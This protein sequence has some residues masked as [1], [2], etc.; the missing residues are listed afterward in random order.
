MEISKAEYKILRKMSQN[1]KMVINNEITDT[2]LS[3]GLVTSEILGMNEDCVTE[4][5]NKLELTNDG[6][7]AYENYHDKI[8]SVRRAN[9]QSWIAIAISIGSLAVSVIALLRN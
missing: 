3:K 8:V 6:V 2:L 5:S 7:I 1:K 4:Y 9:I